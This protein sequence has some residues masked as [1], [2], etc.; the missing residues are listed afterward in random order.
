MELLQGLQTRYSSPKLTEPGPDATQMQHLL[1]AAIRAPD[2]GLLRPWRF[3]TV[4][5]EDRNKLGEVFAQAKLLNQ[6]DCNAIQLERCRQL[7]MRAPTLMIVVANPKPHPKVPE[8]EQIQSAAA[9][10]YG[11]L[12]AAYAQ[13]L[14]AIW[15]TGW[16]VHDS[17][18]RSNLGISL[19]EQI[20]AII[21]L[22]TPVGQ[23]ITRPQPDAANLITNWP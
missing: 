19:S 7:P 5:G 3:I 9:A 15:R 12:M 8:A 6:P 11:I 21:Y 10:A 16:V 14:G 4:A 17:H 1:K 13:Q 20:I 18:V 2:H 22:G 23:A